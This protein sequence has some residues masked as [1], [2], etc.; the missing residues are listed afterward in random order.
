[1]T[2]QELIEAAGRLVD[3][4]REVGFTLSAG[5]YAAH[6]EDL[7]ELI[8]SWSAEGLLIFYLARDTHAAD[9]SASYTMGSGGDIDTSRPQK[10]E[11][12]SCRN[13]DVSFEVD[14]ISANDWSKILDHSVSGKY[15][16]LCYVDGGSPLTTLHVWP[17]PTSGST[18]YIDSYKQFGQ[19]SALGDTVTFP[20]GYIQGLKLDLAQ[21]MAH[22]HRR[23]IPPTVL[24]DTE[25]AKAQI[26][27]LNA[28]VLGL[29]EPVGLPDLPPPVAAPVMAPPGE[30]R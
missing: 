8:N 22:T 9:G 4:V 20:A 30:T 13:S 21:I 2:A 18:L 3:V 17:A 1:M 24:A 23:P 7:N 25:Q 26:R 12:I 5:E 10:I 14:L 28:E 11:A 29:P 16:E 15:A 6:L 27:K 19:F